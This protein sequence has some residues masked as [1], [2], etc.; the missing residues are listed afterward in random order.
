MGGST[1]D[2]QGV[3]G[4]YKKICDLRGGSMKNKRQYL[5]GGSTKDNREGV[6]KIKHKQIWGG[7]YG[8]F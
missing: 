2:L 1:K 6:Y 8:I 5:N 3:R 7:V 4:V